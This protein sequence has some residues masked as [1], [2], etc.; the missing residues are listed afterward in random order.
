MRSILYFAILFLSLACIVAPTFSHAQ[1]SANTPNNDAR[2][3][4][5]YARASDAQMQEAQKY[6]KLCENTDS[7]KSI[8]NCKC[9]AVKY[10]ETR[11][12]LGKKASVDTIIKANLNTCLKNE[13]QLVLPKGEI[14]YS[15]VPKAYMDEAMYIYSYCNENPKFGTNY[16]CQCYAAEFLTKRVDVGRKLSQNSIMIGLRDSCRNVVG[17][18]GAKYNTCMGQFFDTSSIGEGI[19]Q[20]DYC[21]CVADIW[22]RQ[23]KNF[24]GRIDSPNAHREM[25]F[26]ANMA[27]KKPNMYEN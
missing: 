16:D 9:A 13:K 1:N 2:T 6:Y 10:L 20:K 19:T 26:Q 14:D 17:T 8:K 12:E 11:L 5:I 24:T 25:E 27:C 15:K 4:S 18:T 22:A 3:K 21:E 23:Y 7:L